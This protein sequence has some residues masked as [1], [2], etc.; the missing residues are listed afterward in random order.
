MLCK[1][2]VKRKAM[3]YEEAK[4]LG[5]VEETVKKWKEIT[6]ASEE[7]WPAILL[8]WKDGRID[9]LNEGGEKE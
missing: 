4:S 2:E 7:L 6:S 3:S 9:L 5:V 8:D 1:G